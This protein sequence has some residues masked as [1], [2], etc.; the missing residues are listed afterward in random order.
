MTIPAIGFGTWKIPPAETAASVAQALKTGYRLI[1]TAKIYGNEEEVGQA[2]RES[3]VA[4]KDIF[5]TTK[6]WN[7]D[8]GYETTR[9][10]LETSLQK[11]GLDYLDLYLIHWPATSRRHDSWRAMVDAC[12]EGLVKAIGVSNFTIRHLDELQ[13]ES[14]TL[15][16]VNQIEFHP[17]LY[18]QQ[19]HLLNYCYD[20]HIQVEAYSPLSRGVKK[21]NPVVTQVAEAHGVSTAQVL[22]R[23]CLQH[24]TVVL[25]RSANP[26]H[27]A[28]N[29]DVF[30]FE[31]S[32]EEMLALNSLSD[33]SRVTWDPEEM[34]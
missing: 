5:V 2:I 34:Q 8:Q 16:M 23:W 25:P 11:L 24:G 27:I 3:A 26:E 14:D 33:G 20:H 9:Q 12:N 7:E 4:R 21:D 18:D 15:P 31:L 13:R 28:E 30:S 19:K 10:A 22:L 6:L 17:F 1:D 32:P 29:F